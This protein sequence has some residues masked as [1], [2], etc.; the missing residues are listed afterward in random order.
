MKWPS[1]YSKTI[2]AVR[3]HMILA[4]LPFLS[5]SPTSFITWQQGMT[6]P[7]ISFKI[8]P[9]VKG[10]KKY[11]RVEAQSWSHYLGV[12]QGPFLITVV[13]LSTNI[14]A[15]TKDVSH[16]GF[17]GSSM[18]AFMRP[19]VSVILNKK[20]V[21]IPKVSVPPHKSN[22]LFC[23]TVIPHHMIHSWDVSKSKSPL[24][25]VNLNINIP[26]S[27]SGFFY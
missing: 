6:F 27:T 20:H 7:V 18:M 23:K 22:V 24:T 12:L 15:S 3:M 19:A 25:V 5:I 13:N 4:C 21:Q 14:A 16:H 26:T 10:L 17:W 8:C 2:P 1:Q 11:C 9:R